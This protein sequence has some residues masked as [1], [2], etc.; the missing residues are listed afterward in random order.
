MMTLKQRAEQR[1]M[2]KRELEREMDE[3]GRDIARKQEAIKEI[4]KLPGWAIVREMYITEIER[5][6]NELLSI[7]PLRIFKNYELKSELKAMNKQKN[8]IE[9]FDNLIDLLRK[10]KEGEMRK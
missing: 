3:K 6:K 2:K 1:L 10:V 7:S 5:I 9:S 8:I 4:I